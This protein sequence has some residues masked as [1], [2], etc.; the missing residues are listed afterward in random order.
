MKRYTLLLV[1]AALTVGLLFTI[2]G[3]SKDDDNPADAGAASTINAN[4]TMTA[5]SRTQATGTLFVTDQD[6]NAITGLT[7]ANVA[8]S[9]KWGTPKVAVVDSITGA[10]IIQTLSQS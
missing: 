4:G 8:A 1:L 2:N 7:A 10:V 9:M 3:C 5:T 6:G